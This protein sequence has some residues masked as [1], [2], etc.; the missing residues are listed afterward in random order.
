[1]K[2]VQLRHWG[3]ESSLCGERESRSGLLNSLIFDRSS[4]SAKMCP[5]PGVDSSNLFSHSQ[6][7]FLIAV[8]ILTDPRLS[9][10]TI[11]TTVDKHCQYPSNSRWLMLAGS[12]QSMGLL[13]Y[14]PDEFYMESRSAQLFSLDYLVGPWRKSTTISYLRFY[15][16]RL[17]ETIS[18]RSNFNTLPVGWFVFRCH[19]WH[20]SALLNMQT[21]EW[22][23]PFYQ[24]AEDHLTST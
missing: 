15:C 17:R 5:I 7:P 24:I 12:N 19:Q 22:C 3:F 6:G 20:H 23:F 11:N 21:S 16:S 8:M 4:S 10:S 13:S 9:D 2:W 1:M 18:E 14:L